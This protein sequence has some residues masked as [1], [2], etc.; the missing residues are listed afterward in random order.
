MTYDQT[1]IVIRERSFLELVDLGLVVAR[2]RPIVLFVAALAGIAPLAALNIWLLS[3]MAF[4]QVYW[5]ALLLLEAPWA[6][7]PLTLVLG[8]LMF[9]LRPRP[10]RILKGLAIALPKLVLTQLWF[11]G[12][13]VLTVIGYS[14]VPVQVN[15]FTNPAAV[16]LVLTV[17]GYSLVPSQYA[18][19]SEVV[20]LERV[21]TVRS[22]KRASALS[23]DFRGELFMRWL[24][25]VALGL[26]FALCFQ[27]GVTSLWSVLI[28]DKLTWVQPVLSDFGGLLFQAAIW[29]AIAFFAI[30][31]F[32]S[33]IDR[34]IRL[35]GWEIELRLKM[36]SRALEERLQ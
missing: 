3:E 24:G 36:V 32:L 26:T 1:L 10:A 20:L 17:I 11:R 19:L 16:L 6:T 7:A 21:G 5:V 31:R 29:I 2:D 9:G 22:L 8:D 14:L 28:G 34:R 23:R 35:E 13:L 30:V 4:S 27:A 33:Y 12:L 18:F 25:Q 15:A